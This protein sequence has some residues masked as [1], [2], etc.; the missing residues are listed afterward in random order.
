MY[1]VYWM[2]WGILLGLT[3]LMVRLD[4]APLPHG[5]FVVLMLLAMAI[6]A[7]IIAA[8][9]MHLRFERLSLVLGIVIGLPLNAAILYFFIVPD[10]ARIL[11]MLAGY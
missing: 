11:R 7:S 4:R 5:A 6:K 1:R 2:A 9:F 10:A 8:F 3:V